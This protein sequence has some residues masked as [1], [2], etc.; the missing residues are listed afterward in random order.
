MVSPTLWQ[1]V[2]ADKHVPCLGSTI[3]A[4]K[5]RI[6]KLDRQR[7]VARFPGDLG[8][9]ISMARHQS[10]QS[11]VQFHPLTPLCWPREHILTAY[12]LLIVGGG[13]QGLWI[14]RSAILAG[15]SVALVE[16]NVC[17]TGASGGLLGA[18]MPHA[19]GME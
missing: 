3:L 10:Y 16:A 13:V 2:R 12:D 14:A 19:N 6:I 17:G 15:M 18:L 8:K 5:I 7:R 1:A 9:G 11:S 4:R